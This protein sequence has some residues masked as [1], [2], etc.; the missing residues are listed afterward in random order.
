ML[1]RRVTFDPIV[2]EKE[3]TPR[4]GYSDEE[5][6][7]IWYTSRE[8]RGFRLDE[9]QRRRQKQRRQEQQQRRRSVTTTLEAKSS[10]TMQQRQQQRIGHRRCTQQR[11]LSRSHRDSR[12]ESTG[13]RRTATVQ[14][15][16]CNSDSSNSCNDSDLPRRMDAAARLMRSLPTIPL[17]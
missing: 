11:P 14:P 13:G 10:P 15:E 6:S 17:R 3:V 9:S 7:S 1:R 16:S 5:R 4:G 2:R 12:W 8:Y